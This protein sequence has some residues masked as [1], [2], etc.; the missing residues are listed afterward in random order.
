MLLAS[1]HLGGLRWR[2]HITEES[3]ATGWGYHCQSVFANF[4][5]R[6]KLKEEINADRYNPNLIYDLTPTGFYTCNE[7]VDDIFRRSGIGR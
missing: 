3:T 6:R 7:W 4:D 5:Q 2:G 1:E